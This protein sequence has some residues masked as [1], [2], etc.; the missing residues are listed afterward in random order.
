M[1]FERPIVRKLRPKDTVPF[2]CRRC[3]ACCRRL[4]G[5]LMVESLDAYRL[6]NY[7]RT[8]GRPDIEMLDIINEYTEPDILPGNYPIFL[9]K[10][11]GTDD[12]CVFLKEGACSVYPARPR[13]CRLYPFT[14]DIGVRGHDF[15]WYQCMDRPFHFSGGKVLVKDWFYRNFSKE[16]RAFVL[17]EWKNVPEI[18]NLIRDLDGSALDAAHLDILLMRY[19]YFDQEQPF[20]PQ[21]ER[22]TEELLRR[23]GQLRSAA[24]RETPYAQKRP[25][26]GDRTT[27]PEEKE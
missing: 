15:N 12:A 6:A 22:N 21:Y 2:Q 1:P 20:L 25:S 9:M 27:A 16:E 19:T 14:V 8:H 26:D 4:R 13:A 24:E 23:L 7:L 18:G 11:Q 5:Q 3:A 17:Q 10:V